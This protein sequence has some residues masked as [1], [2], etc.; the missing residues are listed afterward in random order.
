MT[1][2][3]QH[4]QVV[5]VIRTSRIAPRNNVMNIKGGFLIET[6]N[7]AGLLQQLRLP[8]NSPLFL[9]LHEEKLYTIVKLV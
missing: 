2:V 3:T 6:T 5:I 8:P 9:R 4:T 7:L 1:C